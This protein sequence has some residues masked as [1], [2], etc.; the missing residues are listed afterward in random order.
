MK[1]REWQRF[2]EE[3]RREHS[4]VLFSVTELANVGGVSRNAINV[5][6]SRLRQQ[7]V[8]VKYAHGCYGL[9]GVVTPEALLPAID[10]HAYM[11]GSYALH[12]HNLVT[13]APSRITCFTDRYS[14]RARERNTPVGRFAL[15][16][17]RSRVYAPPPGS[18]LASPAQALCDVVY[19][20]R[21]EGAAP[22][23]VLTFRNLT[24]LV[25]PEFESV[26]ARYPVT[27]QR[28]VRNLIAGG[29]SSDVSINRKPRR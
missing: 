9:P 25:T 8:I 6:M 3:Q 2:M 21:R 27:V 28:H 29:G 22:E 11:T 16:C 1:A 17:V 15:V 7:G 20:M 4:K 19:L 10:A 5:E 14:P 18:V 13:Q 23:G 24:T 26:L 12:V